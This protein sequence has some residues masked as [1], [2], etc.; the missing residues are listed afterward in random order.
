MSSAVPSAEK[1]YA[2]LEFVV[3]VIRH[4]I[5]AFDRHEVVHRAAAVAFQLTLSVF[6]G[7]IFLFSLVPYVPIPNLTEHIMQFFQDNLPAGMYHDTEGFILDLISKP[8][9][10]LLSLGF[11][12]TLT[13]ATAGVLELM[14][15]F[16][17]LQQTVERRGFLKQRLS[18]FWITNMLLASLFISVLVVL[19]GQ[20]VHNVVIQYLA[21]GPE[22]AN[23]HV[24]GVNRASR[25]VGLA[26]WQVLYFIFRYAV[27][28]GVFLLG[29]SALYYWGPTRRLSNSFFSWGSV[30]ASVV[31]IVLTHAFSTYIANFGTYNK[32]YGS[33]G[34]MIVFMLWIWLLSIVLLT[35]FLVNRIIFQMH[36][37]KQMEEAE[38]S[39]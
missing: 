3:R 10:N 9:G 2:N 20:L 14:S 24:Q 33:I 6:P 35:G 15:T 7:L 1:P 26:V 22:Y 19:V 16:N 8:R 4:T 12:F 5:K 30:T 34:T 28:V 39:L 36:L 23:A 18:A 27:S 32:L 17:R 13:A 21:G 38:N 37:K 11:F 31:A 25:S 29:V